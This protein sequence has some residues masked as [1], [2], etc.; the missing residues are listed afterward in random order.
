MSTVE[1]QSRI[2]CPECG[3]VEEKA[4]P[5]DACLWFHECESCRVVLE[6]R[7]GDCCVFCSYGTVKCPPMCTRALAEKP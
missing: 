3:H 2:T 5:T 7:S 6:P 4:M 1:L